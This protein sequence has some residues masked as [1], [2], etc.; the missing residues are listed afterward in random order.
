MRI[1]KSKRGFAYTAFMVVA[2][3][4]LLISVITVV[5]MK[6]NKFNFKR[7]GD[8]QLNT[9]ETYQNA[10]KTLFLIDQA[11]KYTA[12]E[13][14][15][16]L[17]DN[18]GLYDTASECGDYLGY[19]IWYDR[20]EEC[21]PK[22]PENEFILTYEK[23]L[24]AM[25]SGIIAPGSF[26]YIILQSNPLKIA[27]A[28]R[29]MMEFPISYS[30]EDPIRKTEVCQT[31]ELEQIP[32]SIVCSAKRCLLRPEVAE[33]LV[34]AQQIAQTKGYQLQ[35]TS[36]Y[37]TYEDQA[38]MRAAKGEMAALPS[39]NAPHVTGG[40]V[41]VVLKGQPYMTSSGYPVSDMSLGDR[42]VLEE[43]MCKAGFV[44]YSGEFWHYEYGTNRWERGKAAEVCAI[45]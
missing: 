17:A 35:V 1:I 24:D 19:S 12:Y 31:P 33:K 5:L 8:L 3:L 41:D 42:K 15:H 45:V 25:L 10:E 20:D 14:V 43:V 29:D 23:N 27:G 39:C 38:A 18:G 37:R 26:E 7:A 22:N 30:T 6:E 40:A 32:D 34:Q 9:I 21:Y 44:R 11:A 2:V 16:E 4:V 28:S 36:A 13:S